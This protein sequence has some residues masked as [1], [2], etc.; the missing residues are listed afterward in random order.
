MPRESDDVFRRHLPFRRL[1][2]SQLSDDSLVSFQ[3]DCDGL[4]IKALA[5]IQGPAFDPVGLERLA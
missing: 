5:F 1:A 4:R 2:Q 3:E